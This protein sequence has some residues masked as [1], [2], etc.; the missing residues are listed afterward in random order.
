MT[1]Q[2]FLEEKD[3]IPWD[4]LEYVVGH[5]NY[6][7]RVTDDNDRRCLIAILR[8]YLAPDVLQDDHVFT[9]SGLYRN[10]ATAKSS[11]AD[12]Q[13]YVQQLAATETPDV[14]GMHGNATIQSQLQDSR[15]LLDTVAAVQPAVSTSGS[16][17]SA[18][19]VVLDLCA[20]LLQRIP[21]ALDKLEEAK[22]GLFKRDEQGKLNSL[23]VVLSQEMDRFNQLTGQTLLLPIPQPLSRLGHTLKPLIMPLSACFFMS[24]QHHCPQVGR[25]IGAARMPKNV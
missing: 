1:I 16:G 9:P 22:D 14:F 2:M 24:L 3:A 25:L 23:S 21:P 6:G 4:A 20:D 11:L 15:A 5:V 17:K 8:R 12:I 19:T 13:L 18:E 10:P 7:G